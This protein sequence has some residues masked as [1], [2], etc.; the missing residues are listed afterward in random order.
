M[1]QKEENRVKV[2]GREDVKREIGKNEKG[3]KSK[4]EEKRG[5]KRQRVRR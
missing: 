2:R 3:E 1:V 5:A 4:R